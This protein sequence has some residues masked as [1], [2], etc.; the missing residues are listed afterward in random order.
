MDPDSPD[1]EFA[2]AYAPDVHVV[3]SANAPV[4]REYH[5]RGGL[6]RAYK[7]WLEPFSEF[8]VEVLDVIDAGDQVLIP[9]LHRAKGAGSG[10]EVEQRLVH[11]Y[12]IRDGQVA[13]IHEYDTLDEAW[14]AVRADR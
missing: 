12:T 9:Q 1:T 11:V 13:A 8:Y 6:I 10:V 2:A 4:Q 7:D 3:W 5:G 14:E